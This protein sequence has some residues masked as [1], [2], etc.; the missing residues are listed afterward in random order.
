LTQ[1]LYWEDP[2]QREFDARVIETSEMDGHSAVVLDKTCFYP[3][4]GGQPHDLG[5]LNGVAVLDVVEMDGRIL[6]V[7][8]ESLTTADAHG[9]ID[10]SRRFDHMQQH[11]GQHILSAA[12]ERELDGATVSFHLGSESSTIDVA[13]P[14][15]SPEQVARVE[16]LSNRIVM[17]NRAVITREYAPKETAPLP[18]R[19]PPQ[20]GGPIRVVTVEGFDVCAC[21]GTHVRTTGEIGAIHI[22]GWE[23]RRGATRVAFLCGW[24]A[25][26]DYQA[27]DRSCQ[28]LASAL[29]VGTSEV[30]EAMDRLI[31]A[32][33]AARRQSNDLRQRL[34]D[35]EL[36]QLA[37]EAE[38]VGG[39]RVL[40]RVLQGYDA[41][42]MRYIAQHL[43]QEPN[44]VAL[45]AVTSPSP[46]VCFSRSQDLDIDMAQLLREATAPYGGKGGGRP[47]SAQGGGVAAQDLERVLDDARK[48]LTR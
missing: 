28:A 20:V 15:L 12:F 41:G 4:S 10:W 44:M 17:E 30:V 42:N 47:H 37:G 39:M 33:Q 38:R 40:C 11:T 32:E 16:K 6:H 35:C 3:T 2:Y 29:S 8:S 36:P 45:L 31:E 26:R 23:R 24:R 48:R 13:L 19:K 5:T 21:G 25:V 9:M 43:C 18:L 27:K 14:A 34:L 22:R 46:Q 1:H 7:L